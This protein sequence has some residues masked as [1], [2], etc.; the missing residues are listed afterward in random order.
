MPNNEPTWI[1]I[2][3]KEDGTPDTN[4][5]EELHETK[6]HNIRT[7]SKPFG[8]DVTGFDLRHLPSTFSRDYRNFEDDAKIKR[9]YYPEVEAALKEITGGREVVIFDHTIRRR[10]SS[11]VA[12]DDPSRRQPVPRVHIDQ[13]PLAAEQ[14]VRRHTG[15][16]AEA[17][18]KKRYQLI[19]FWRPI[20]HAAEDTPL[21][22]AS[23]KTIVPERDLVATKLLYPAPTPDGETYNVLHHPD[24]EFYYVKAQTPEEVTLIKCFDSDQTVAGLT[25]HT[26][27]TD[28]NSDPDAPLRQSIEVRCL[29]FHD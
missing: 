8:I 22:L 25:P 15:D 14:R 28:P 13:T 29:V 16:R 24:Q 26:A 1:S 4:F 9:E 5:N 18:L 12:D 23:Y 7:T 20:Q 2:N 27:F 21:A 3:S 6:I 10:Q 17:L 11:K 19:N